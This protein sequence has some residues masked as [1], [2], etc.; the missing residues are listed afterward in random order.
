MEPFSVIGGGPF[1]VV[2]VRAAQYVRMSAEHQQYSTLNQMD[3]LRAYAAARC[4][5][6]VRTYADEGKSGLRLEGRP[7]LRQLIQDV[8]SGEAPFS[9]ILVYDVSR[10]GRFQDADESAHYEFLCRQAGINVEYCAE[11]FANDGNPVSALLKNMKRIMAAEYSRELSVKVH[12]AQS[13]VA[14]LGYLIGGP[15]SF[16]FRRLAVDKLGEPRGIL[17][18]GQHKAITT[19][20]VLLVPGPQK[21]VALVRWIFNECASGKSIRSIATTLNRRGIPTPRG[22]LWANPVLAAMLRNEKYIGNNIWNRRSYKLRLKAVKNPPSAWIRVDGAFKPIISRKLFDNVQK[23]VA[24]RKE[25]RPSEELLDALKGLLARKGR[26]TREIILA[27]KKT[28]GPTC[29]DERFGGLVEAYKRIGYKP[30]RDY[31]H[32][33]AYRY[34]RRVSRAKAVEVADKL[35][36]A[37]KDVTFRRT[38]WSIEIDS[39]FTL[40]FMTIRC[41]EARSG[42]IYWQILPAFT[43]RIDLVVATRMKKGNKRIL[44]YLL[45]PTDEL[46]ATSIRLH[47]EYNHPL[48]AYRCDTLEPLVKMLARDEDAPIRKRILDAIVDEERERPWWR[49]ERS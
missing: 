29:Y 28:P 21:E 33:D 12:F 10:W 14:K 9:V 22:K 27:D 25:P 35:R 30:A 45:I 17:E 2:P 24:R 13:R 47:P 15:A 32:L 43:S 44:D 26:L 40:L 36:N 4:I 19:D 23:M 31:S 46:K 18:I 48:K 39:Q 7:A 16:G 37:G 8:V 38:K 11:Q 6:I 41:S 3:V 49:R 5:D 42:M 34:F 1:S 20:R